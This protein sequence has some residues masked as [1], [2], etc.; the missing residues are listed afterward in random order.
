MK[1]IKIALLVQKLRRFSVWV[2]FAYWWSYNNNNNNNNNNGLF[3]KWLVIV[4]GG[5]NYI[6]IKSVGLGLHAYNYDPLV[7][8]LCYCSGLFSNEVRYGMGEFLSLSV[9][10]IAVFNGI[11]TALVLTVSPWASNQV[12]WCGCSMAF[13]ACYSGFPY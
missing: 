3:S 10:V 11:L 4:H 12:L 7:T 2:D 9:L 1:G 13:L 6:L 5:L 8:M